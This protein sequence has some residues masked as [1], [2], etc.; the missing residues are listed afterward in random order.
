[1]FIGAELADPMTAAATWGMLHGV[2]GGKACALCALREDQA[3]LGQPSAAPVPS[4][5]TAR[6]QKCRGRFPI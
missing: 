3:N 5:S 6:A 4:R 1:M 2:A